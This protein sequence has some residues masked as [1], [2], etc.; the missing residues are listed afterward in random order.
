MADDFD[1]L[2]ELAADLTDAPSE[3]APFVKQALKGT[4]MGIKKDWA[5]RAKIS[6]S[7]YPKAYPSSIDFD[8][9][10]TSDGP[11]VEIGPNL[12]RNGGT[13]GFFDEPLSSAGLRRPPMHAGRAALEAA[14]ADF[15]RGIGKALEDGTRKALGA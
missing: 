10:D 7:G 13:A 14:E 11:E 4:A 12:D 5:N 9:S 1:G 6:R 15:E 2:L 3:V 8:E